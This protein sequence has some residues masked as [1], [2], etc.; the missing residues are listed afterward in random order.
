MTMK[1]IVYKTTNILTGQYYIGKHCQK[2]NEFDGYFGSGIRIIRAIKK[3]GKENFIRET[4]GKYDGDKLAYLAEIY[5]MGDCWATDPLCYNMSAGGH[6]LGKGFKMLKETCKKMGL[7]R[8]GSK[9]NDETKKRMSLAQAGENNP[10]YG[11]KHTEQKKQEISDKLKGKYTGNKCSS[12]KGYYITP[13]G[14]FESIREVTKHVTGISGGAVR[15]WCQN[16]DKIIT[17]SMIGMSKYLTML[18]LGKTFKDLGFY[19]EKVVKQ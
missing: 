19:F 7:S 12:F 5:I 13:F 9:R 16:S 15:T 11:K 2:S 17:K 1:Y 6:G 18:D 14:K 8:L 10:M 4:L 3:Y